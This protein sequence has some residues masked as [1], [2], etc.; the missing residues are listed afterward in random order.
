MSDATTPARK[1]HYASLDLPA[2]PPD[3]P[4]VL[5]NMVMSIDGK[6]VIEGTERGLGSAVD[7]RLMSELRVNADVVMNGAGTL[8]ASGT[9][10]RV[11]EPDLRHLRER[12]GK[13]G[14]PIAAVLSASGDL[15]LGR[16]FFT[17][18]DFE[19]VVYVTHDTPEARR[20]AIAATGREVFVLQR[21]DE[22]A[23]MLCHMRH[24][25]DADV[26]LVEGGPTL[27]A[28]LFTAGFVDE[29]F[30][31]VGPV[32]VG[33]KD[34]PT[35][36]EGKHHATFESVARMQLLSAVHNPETSEIYLRYRT[37]GRGAIER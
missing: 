19:A 18:D 3:R 26:L 25:L 29:Y 4:Y 33:G 11:R 24:N 6:V 35:A 31:T 15:P 30:V 28:Q 14:D 23:S 36:V 5:I 9:S 32:V 10:S 34:V 7:H 22:L 8:R 20:E 17:A 37:A 16:S 21:G 2:P 1:P 27:N 12:R 13:P